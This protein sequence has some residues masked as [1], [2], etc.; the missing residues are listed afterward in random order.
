MLKTLFKKQLLELAAG[1][2]IDK[3]TGKKRNKIK[4]IL[5]ASLFVFLF[6]SLASAFFAMSF[7]AG[8]SLINSEFEWIHF[9]LSIFVALPLAVFASMFYTSSAI[10]KSKDNDLLLAMPIS[11]KHILASRMLSIFILIFIYVSIVLLPGY[12]CY[13]IIKDGLTVIAVVSEIIFI[14]I[15]AILA[16]S[17]S[18]AIGYLVTLIS[19]KLKANNIGKLILFLIFFGLYYYVCF[20]LESLV[21]EFISNAV[22]YGTIIK[23]YAYPLYL[24]AKACMGDIVSLL[25]VSVS[26]IV[27]FT[28]VYVILSKSFYKLTLIKDET[29]K[30]EYKSSDIKANNVDKALFKKEFKHYLGSITYM[31]NCSI[32][33]FMMPVAGILLLINKDSF[34]GML[35]E[36]VRLF[37]LDESIIAIGVLAVVCMFASM[38]Y[39]TAPSISLEGN[40][41]WI[42]QSMPVDVRKIFKAKLNLHYVLTIPS[43]LFLAVCLLLAFNVEFSLAILVIVTVIVYVMFMASLS[44][45]LNV[46]KPNL[47]WTSEVVPIKQDLVIMISLFGGWILSAVIAVGGYFALSYIQGN[48]YIIC[49]MVL[50]SLVSRFINNWLA[51][52]GTQIFTKL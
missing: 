30:K 21:N 52:K 35:L 11:Y 8:S 42:L 28:V 22:I 23:N 1:I 10:Y 45:M 40:S 43:A 51:T 19:A 41:I 49:V 16:L 15:L 38:T 13:W 50:F 3:K 4:T 46:L 26:I 44:L 12:I 24:M 37:E 25:I 27:I 33:S 29:K 47:I 14:F 5:Y 2:Y 20:N 48:Y 7:S 31:L 6:A 18:C 17:L 32:G 9:V 36:L 39:I 34:V